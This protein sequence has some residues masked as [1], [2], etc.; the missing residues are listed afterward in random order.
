[1]RLGAKQGSGSIPVLTSSMLSRCP[2][3]VEK[4]MLRK[5]RLAWLGVIQ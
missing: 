3:S 4:M 5:M 2:E 1:M